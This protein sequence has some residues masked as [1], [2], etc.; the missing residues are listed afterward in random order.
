MAKLVKNVAMA[1]SGVYTYMRHEVPSLGLSLDS[2]PIAYQTM[3]HFNVYRPASVLAKAAPLYTRLPVTV[4]HPDRAIMPSN[5]KQLMEGFTGDTAQAVYRDGEVYID[6]TLTLVAEDAIAYYDKGY[7]EVSPGYTTK[8]KWLPEQKSYKGMPYQ[9]VVTDISDV[10]HLALTLS[11]RGGPSTRVLDSKGGNMAKLKSGLFHTVAKALGM[12]KDSVPVRTQLA[13]LTSKD[14]TEDQIKMTVDSVMKRAE[15]LP[16]SEG[17]EQ[18]TR[19]LD[20]L[21]LVKS[22]DSALVTDAVD[23]TSTLYETLDTAAEVKDYSPGATGAAGA[24]SQ[25]MIEDEKP[26]AVVLKK[27]KKKEDGTDSDE[28]EEDEPKKPV[29]DSVEV[30]LL[31]QILEAVTTKPVVADST[32]APVQTPDPVSAT[33]DSTGASSGIADFMKDFLK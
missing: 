31:R 2:M 20:D 8:S 23:K 5:S 24:G 26:V 32:P 9:I 30:T 17:K 19:F 15:T 14:V 33:L 29:T 21:R 25:K 11:A 7:K 22:F 1:H 16:D 6:S 3:E 10:N 18:L 13:A 27:K 4:E 28:D 12:A